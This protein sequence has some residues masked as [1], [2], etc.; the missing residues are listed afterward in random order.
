MS[1]NEVSNIYNSKT[2]ACTYVALTT[3]TRT[4]KNEISAITNLVM[5]Y[6]AVR[7]SF[8]NHF[9]WSFRTRTFFFL[10]GR[11]SSHRQLRFE[12]AT[13]SLAMFVSLV[14]LTPL[15]LLTPL[16]C[17]AALPAL[18]SA[19]LRYARSLH[20]GGYSL[21]WLTPFQGGWNSNENVFTL[22]TLCKRMI[23]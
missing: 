19:L 15:T 21:T 7:V 4:I 11:V 10:L 14:P 12:A 6:D 1:K 8:I 16:T 5:T 22:L 3:Y 20:S 13:W 23:S 2:M 18:H 17:F 9:R